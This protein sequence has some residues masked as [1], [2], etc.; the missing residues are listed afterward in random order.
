MDDH[1]D[2]ILSALSE[3]GAKLHA[4]LLRI[5]LREDVSEDLM[6]DL[7]LR[8]YR[9]GNIERIQNLEAYLM[10]AATRLAFDWRRSQ[11]RRRDS[12]KLTVEP[13]SDTTGHAGL[14]EQREE[15]D[16]LLDD[17]GRLPDSM[18]ELVVM[19]YLE[20]SSYEDIA[21]MLDKSPHQVRALCHKAIT[22]LRKMQ[23]TDTVA[24]KPVRSKNE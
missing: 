19:R 13:V 8:L 2:Q 7:F 14:I 22:K 18:R 15:L 3:Q 4:M 24:D 21:R 12:D 1:T 11:R 20:E 16:R 23:D 17:V 9:R 5:T 10:T 6:Q